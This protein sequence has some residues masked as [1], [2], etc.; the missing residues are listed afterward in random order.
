MCQ[1][2]A[3]VVA[4]VVT[5]NTNERSVLGPCDVLCVQYAIYAYI[6]FLARRPNSR[7]V[8]A[9]CRRLPCR[10]YHIKLLRRVDIQ[11][12]RYQ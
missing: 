2:E 9:D 1:V 6:Y 3:L 8:W 10:R 5:V 4:P 12:R 11:R 7:L